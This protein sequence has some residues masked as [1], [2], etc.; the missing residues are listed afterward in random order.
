MCSRP[1]CR[2]PAVISLHHSPAAMA[3]PYLAPKRKSVAPS[4]PI[5]AFS[6]PLPAL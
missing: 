2:K 1:P 6:L 3:G 5:Q 4:T